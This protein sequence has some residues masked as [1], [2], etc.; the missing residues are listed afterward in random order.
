VILASKVRPVKLVMMAQL[1]QMAQLDKLVPEVERE[2]KENRVP[3][4]R[5]ARMV[6]RV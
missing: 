4:V 3:L 1:E 6:Q 2:Q 5:E